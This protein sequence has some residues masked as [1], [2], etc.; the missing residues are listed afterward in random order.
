M[1]Q[2]VWLKIVDINEFCHSGRKSKKRTI[3]HIAL[4]CK[5]HAPS[6][7]PS[8]TP[9][10]ACTGEDFT[11]IANNAIRYSYESLS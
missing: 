1:M 3:P 5:I 8:D 4:M 9:I 10:N 2:Q 11:D 6:N 7:F